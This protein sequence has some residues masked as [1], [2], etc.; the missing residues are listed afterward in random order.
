MIVFHDLA[1]PEVVKGFQYFVQRSPEWKTRI[2][3]TQQIMGV[4][5]RGHITPPRHIPDPKFVWTLPQ[6]LL[7]LMKEEDVK[8][9]DE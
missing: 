7:D 8:F 9:C 6:H 5:W 2:Y 1:F 4:A 3:H